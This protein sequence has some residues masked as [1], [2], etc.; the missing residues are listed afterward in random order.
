MENPNFGYLGK[1]PLPICF[2]IIRLTP[3]SGKVLLILMLFCFTFITMVGGNPK[4]DAYGF[5]YWRDP[6]A[7]AEYVTTGSL[8]KF[9]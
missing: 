3:S 8:G 1:D 2:Y 5:R 9:E 7:F 6:G 4:H